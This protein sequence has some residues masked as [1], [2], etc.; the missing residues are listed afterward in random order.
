MVERG[1]LATGL[2]DFDR[3]Y[4]S[5]KCRVLTRPKDEIRCYLHTLRGGMRCSAVEKEE[6][7]KEE[8]DVFDATRDVWR[9]ANAEEY[10]IGRFLL[11]NGDYGWMIYRWLIKEV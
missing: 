11:R 9:G 3:S 8:K 1:S 2:P 4:G 10:W 5:G 6:R 7:E